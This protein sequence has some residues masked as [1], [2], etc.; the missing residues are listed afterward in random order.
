MKE[1]S[2]GR[3]ESR[4]VRQRGQWKLEDKSSC[5]FLDRSQSASRAKN[6][7]EYCRLF[8]FENLKQAEWYFK[9]SSITLMTAKG[10]IRSCIES[11]SI[12]LFD[13]RN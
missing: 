10:K 11:R 5:F 1:I 2:F 4:R 7:T 8:A 6:E 13:I 3:E 12:R 9:I